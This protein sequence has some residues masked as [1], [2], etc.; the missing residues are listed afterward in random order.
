M[1]NAEECV[2]SQPVFV[3]QTI[4]MAN[5]VLQNSPRSALM[6]TNKES[7]AALGNIVTAALFVDEIDKL[8]ANSG[9]VEALRAAAK[10]NSPIRL[11]FQTPATK[12]TA[13]AS[14]TTAVDT[15]ENENKA[16]GA[17]Q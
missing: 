1:R 15:T 8:D 7:S 4:N 13:A 14:P 17:A 6:E 9:E 2:K 16:P 12:T 11:K 3:L 10:T 5:F